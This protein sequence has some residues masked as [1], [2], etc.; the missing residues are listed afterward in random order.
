LHSAEPNTTTTKKV[1]G[2]ES[3]TWYTI[4]VRVKYDINGTD[5][6]SFDTTINSKTD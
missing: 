6:F 4:S 2:L 1:T 3:N 5:A